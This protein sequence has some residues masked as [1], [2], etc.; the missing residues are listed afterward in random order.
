MPAA[1]GGDMGYRLK[2]RSCMS[3]AEVVGCGVSRSF[4]FWKREGKGGR[5]G[6]DSHVCSSLSTMPLHKDV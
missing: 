4:S 2:G 6:G 1:P 5:W 3:E